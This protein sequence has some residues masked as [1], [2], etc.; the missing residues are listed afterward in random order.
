MKP[1]RPMVWPFVLAGGLVLFF[2]G[3]VAVIAFWFTD[4][5]GEDTGDFPQVLGISQE[6]AQLVDSW[7]THTGFLGDGTSYWQLT[8]SP[9]KADSVEKTLETTPGWR[10]LPV[11]IE[12]E[13]LLY[14]REWQEGG[15]SFGA[16]PYL[17]DDRTGEALLP[18]V[19]EGYWF[20]YNLQTESFDTTGV[21]DQP[22]QNFVAAVYDTQTHTLTCG[23]LDT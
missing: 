1:T 12:G 14:G 22:S 6:S 11:S 13:I 4:S 17:K 23:R 2:G 15:A 16:G 8:F 9:E 10:P 3:V 7:D 20:F 18:Q 19:E 21:T 5:T